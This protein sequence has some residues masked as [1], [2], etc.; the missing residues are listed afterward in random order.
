MSINEKEINEFL[1]GYLFL[2]KIDIESFKSSLNNSYLFDSD[3]LY[4]IDI[5]LDNYD[6]LCALYY[7][8]E[9]DNSFDPLDDYESMWCDICGGTAWLS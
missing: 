1:G 6:Y 5:A 4:N 7:N 8:D 2:K 9:L 3:L